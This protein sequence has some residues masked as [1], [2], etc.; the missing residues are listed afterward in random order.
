[1][2][3]LSKIFNTTYIYLAVSY[4]FTDCE[5]KNGYRVYK[6]ICLSG[7]IYIYNE[8]I[9]YNLMRRANWVEHDIY[10]TNNMNNINFS[11]TNS[12]KVQTKSNIITKILFNT[13][14]NI[15]SNKSAFYYYFIYCDFIVPYIKLSN[16]N[17][18][19]INTNS[20]KCANIIVK[21]DDGEGGDAILIIK[22]DEN[23]N[24]NVMTHIMNNTKY[25]NWT[26]SDLVISKL[27][28]NRI[29]SNRVY[30]L[31]VINYF[32]MYAN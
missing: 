21:P 31:I 6:Q 26:V 23:S 11:L 10:N 27:Y 12:Q 2:N 32:M 8:L 19:N 3:K 4:D 9:K 15:F 7:G 16:N 5:Y 22:N 25:A 13:P 24:N 14:Q 29:V 18:N 1:M 30:M 20:L 17:I 28:N